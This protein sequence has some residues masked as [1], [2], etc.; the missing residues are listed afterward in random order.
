MSPVMR[1]CAWR[2]PATRRGCTSLVEARKGG[3][4]YCPEHQPQR[5]VGP[6]SRVVS[7]VRWKRLRER[8][9]DRHER[10]NGTWV[11]GICDG[12]ITD[13]K[14]IEVDHIVAVSMGGAAYDEANLRVTHKRCNRRLG[15]Q[16]VKRR[17]EQAYA[18]MRELRE[19]RDR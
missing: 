10:S 9:I 12:T 17:R 19:R 14:D 7:T 16:V 15:G 18:R 4:S 13:R 1:P 2:D 5:Q 6:S 8:V 11:C 3:P